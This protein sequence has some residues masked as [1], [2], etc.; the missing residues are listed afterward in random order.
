CARGSY[1]QEYESGVFRYNRFDV[2]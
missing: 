1:D 2:W